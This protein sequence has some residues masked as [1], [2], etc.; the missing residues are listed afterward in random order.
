MSSHASLS[1]WTGLRPAKDRA[2]DR[3]NLVQLPE[4]EEA[5]HARLIN[6]VRSLEKSH[7]A[8]HIVRRDPLSD[9]HYWRQR[10]NDQEN[11]DRQKTCTFCK[12]TG[13][14]TVSDGHGCIDVDAC[15][16]CQR[17]YV[18]PYNGGDEMEAPF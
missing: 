14:I 18:R 11:K 9:L 17:A 1:T 4:A 8:T 3:W 16:R 12:G 5:R 7:A 6:A 10:I 13:E 15:P 2:A